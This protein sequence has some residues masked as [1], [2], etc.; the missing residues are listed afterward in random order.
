MQ[1]GEPKLRGLI[2]ALAAQVQLLEDLLGCDEEDRATHRKIAEQYKVPLVDYY[3][4]LYIQW[5]EDVRSG[6]LKDDGFVQ[7][8]Q[9]ASQE[10]LKA[11]MAFSS[12]TQR[13]K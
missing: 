6:L 1:E 5:D 9:A 7:R 8:K 3:T 10:T 12:N 13:H 2:S 4:D 11:Q